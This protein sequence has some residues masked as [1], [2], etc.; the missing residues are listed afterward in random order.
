MSADPALVQSIRQRLE[1]H[2]RR[3]D[4]DIGRTLV[5][6]CLER[7]L[8]RLSLSEHRDG[9]L[10]KGAMLFHVWEQAPFRATA[11]L[12]LLGFGDNAE[13]AVAARV[14]AIAA[15]DPG[16]DDAVRFDTS[17]MAVAPLRLATSYTGVAVK[18]D[19]LLG[20]ARMRMQIDVGFG[21]AVTPGPAAIRFPTLLD[22]PAPHLLSY[23]VETVVAEKL[24]A[25]VSI[26]FATTRIKDV[27]DLWAI[28]TSFDLELADLHAAVT[29][30]FARR[31]TN[32]PDEQPSALSDR[33]ATDTGKQQ[34]WAA[35]TRTRIKATEAPGTLAEAISLIRVF[36]APVLIS[37]A[38]TQ[39][40]RW[41]RDTQQW[42]P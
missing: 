36:V 16:E 8:Y 3:T 26:G 38:P 29:A 35:F 11:D 14:A 23:P 6:Y 28:A 9:F 10:L 17:R 34:L 39:E 7:F 13:Q 25:L 22:Q 31:G 32:W 42:V 40:A 5:R 1:N 41:R 24:E 18:F 4:E 19:A 33:F 27:Y 12:D 21:D 20:R 15:T 30:T 37:L 2:A